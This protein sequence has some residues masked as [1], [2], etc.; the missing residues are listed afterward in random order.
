MNKKLNYEEKYSKLLKD[1]EYW[2]NQF[3]INY[4][5][6]YL[7]IDTN[8]LFKDFKNIIYILVSST[9]TM[10]KHFKEYNK[11]VLFKDKVIMKHLKG[12]WDDIANKYIVEDNLIEQAREWEEAEEFFLMYKY[13]EKIEKEFLKSAISVIKR[14]VVKNM[15]E[16][17]KWEEIFYECFTNSI[18]TYWEIHLVNN[19]QDRSLVFILFSAMQIILKSILEKIKNFGT[20][21]NIILYSFY[22]DFIN[23]FINEL[24]N[25]E[26]HFVVWYLS[27]SFGLL[28]VR[29]IYETFDG[30]ILELIEHL[31]EY[32]DVNQ[33]HKFK[34]FEF[35]EHMLQ[36]IDEIAAYI[37]QEKNNEKN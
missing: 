12:F 4:K 28:K 10:Y 11:K 7:D 6:E 26:L 9:T 20:N 16:N 34:G 32:D 21:P 19:E 29:K 36:K 27:T 5:N 2:I 31:F 8:Q 23:S 13:Q 24:H 17:K 30:L 33:K 25:N 1:V 22:R 35:R 15:L 37:L 3:K 18:K 14:D